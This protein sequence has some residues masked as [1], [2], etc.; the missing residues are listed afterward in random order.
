MNSVDCIKRKIEEILEK[1]SIP[2]DPIHSKNT[3]KW[4][5][6]LM[7]DADDALKIAAL[8]HDIERAIEERK[9]MKTDY[10]N[11]EEFKDAHALNSAKILIELMK[12]CNA[13][14]ELLDD[15]FFLVAHHEKGGNKRAEALKNADTI[16][17]FDVNLPL[18][19]ARNDVEETKKRFLW[20]YK[21]LPKNL[22]ETVAKFNYKD[23]RLQ[24]LV[25]T[26]ITEVQEKSA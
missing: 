18:Y 20:G 3:L 15:V 7:P 21:K 8:G 5:L 12:E 9:A 25:R 10:K 13:S 2:E 23:K 6:R 19:Y 17:F 14:K 24:S 1:S 16:S 26:W 4:L 22:Q 11:Y